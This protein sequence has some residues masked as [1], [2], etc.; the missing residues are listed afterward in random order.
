MNQNNRGLNLACAVLWTGVLSIVFSAIAT[1][2]I[3]KGRA[4]T[5]SLT[6]IGKTILF[7]SVFLGLI[8]AFKR[9]SNAVSM[10]LGGGALA[11]LLF[12]LAD[13]AVGL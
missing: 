1:I 4:S 11:L 3:E 2:L 12:F 10:F 6:V 5:D 8:L 9:D 7:L 13:A